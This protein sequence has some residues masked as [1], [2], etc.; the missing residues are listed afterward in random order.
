LSIRVDQILEGWVN[1]IRSKRPNM[2]SQEMKTISDYRAIICGTC[3]SLKYSERKLATKIISKYKC[4]EC[5]CSFPMMT[6]SRKKKCPLG[7][8]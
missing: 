8:W 6:F 1:F 3:D 4:N 7:K 2:L 5:G